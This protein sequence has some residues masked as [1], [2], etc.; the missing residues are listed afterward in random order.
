MREGFGL[1]CLFLTVSD[2]Q[3]DKRKQRGETVGMNGWD[4]QGEWVGE[5]PTREG[6]QGPAAHSRVPK[7]LISFSVFQKYSSPLSTFPPAKAR[8]STS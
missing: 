5:I 7:E 2:E 6:T 8:I 4:P 3:E 1:C